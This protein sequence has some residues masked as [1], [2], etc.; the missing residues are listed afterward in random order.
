M[1]VI[2]LV[3]GLV[4]ITSILLPFFIGRGGVLAASSSINSN[5]QL[6]ELK[7][8]ILNQYLTEESAHKNGD[9]NKFAWQKRQSFLVNRY[10]DCARRLDFLS[11][12]SQEDEVSE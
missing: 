4:L 6:A 10:I 9:L 11:H 5:E 8:A 12:V 2:M 1:F 3:A 7:Q